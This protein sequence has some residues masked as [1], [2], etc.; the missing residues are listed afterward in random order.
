MYNDQTTD[1]C[2]RGATSAFRAVFR[3]EFDI[4]AVSA[5]AGGRVGRGIAERLGNAGREARP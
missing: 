5:A 3:G 2:T 1:G 4:S